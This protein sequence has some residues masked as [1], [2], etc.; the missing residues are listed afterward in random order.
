MVGH[1]RY[2]E[3]VEA[4]AR[5]VSLAGREG[6]ELYFEDQLLEDQSGGRALTPDAV[7]GLDPAGT[8]SSISPAS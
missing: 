2:A 5:L 4:L 7:P 3:F 8:I 1:P 6:A